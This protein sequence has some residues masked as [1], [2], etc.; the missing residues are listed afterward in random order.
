[1]AA[2]PEAAQAE[3][4]PPEVVEAVPG[5]GAVEVDPAT[6]EV[7]V[8]FDQDMRGGFS[9]TGGGEVYPEVTGK[10][11]W[12]TPRTCV[13]PVKLQPGKFYRLGIN[14]TSHGNFRGTNGARARVRALYFVTAGAVAEEKDKVVA[15]T[16][17]SM[18]PANDS[19]GVPA[20]ETVLT[21]KFDRPM[22]GGFS[23]TKTG[24]GA[25]PESTGKPTWAEDRQ[26]CQLPVRLTADTTYELRLNSPHH[27]NFSS[28]WGVP[29]EPVLWRFKTGG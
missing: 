22:G 9:W 27:I 15:P 21:V 28:Q 10:P 26:T 8:T 1:V 29:L 23:W 4:A 14:S 3:Q 13:L 7:R 19:A 12:E 18:T 25:H 5:I 16:I 17:V 24:G 2:A 20:G 11:Q 6:T